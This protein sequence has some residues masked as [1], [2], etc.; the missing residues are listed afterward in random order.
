MFH[1]DAA[2]Q[3]AKDRQRELEDAVLGGPRAPKWMGAWR[4][5]IGPLAA[6]LSARISA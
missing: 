4:R 2:Y 5:R 3:L 1:P 6:S